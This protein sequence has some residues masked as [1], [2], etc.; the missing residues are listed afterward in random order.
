MKHLS[1]AAT[2]VFALGCTRAAAP[3]A[4]TPSNSTGEAARLEP[5]TAATDAGP[6]PR[7]D[8]AVAHAAPPVTVPDADVRALLDEWLRAQNAGDFAAYERVYASRFTGIRR[9]GPR[10]RR[11]DRAGW[12]ADRQAMFRAA[13]QVAARD[14]VIDAASGV[15]TVRLTQEFTQGAF[16]DVGRKEM[17]LVRSGSTLQIAR[18]EMLDSTLVAT[19][20]GVAPPAQGAFLPTFEVEGARYAIVAA[21]DE[22]WTEGAAELL[23]PGEVV[24]SRKAARMSALPEALRGYASQRFRFYDNEGRSCESTLGAFSVVSRVDVHFGVSQRWS[25]EDPDGTRHAAYT[26]A[27]VAAEAFD[28]GAQVLV[29]RLEDECG[30]GALWAQLASQRPAVGFRSSAAPAPLAAAVLQRFRALPAWRAAETAY[31]EDGAAIRGRSWDAHGGQAPEVALWQAP[32]NG[33]RFAVVSASTTVGGCGEFSG[34]MTAVFEVTG[35]QTLVLQTD[36]SGPVYVDPDGAADLDGDGRPEFI[37]AEGLFRR[38]GTVYRPQ[39][40]YTV[41]NNDCPC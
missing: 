14:V 31:R 4:A 1:V 7:A 32:N 21:A 34:S 41:P 11:F 17:V 24:V 22:G 8:A 27:E 6:T 9:S 20:D 15:A 33:R 26:P 30:R 3:P 40:I 28:M 2:L 23:S 18:E 37:T 16:H 29:A 36:G 19:T 10:V 12:V 38:M 13:M 35:A 25:G 5:T 39:E